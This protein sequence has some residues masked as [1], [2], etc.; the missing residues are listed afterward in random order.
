MGAGRTARLL[1]ILGAFTAGLMLC[2]GIIVFV[3]GRVSG[4]AVVQAASVGGPFNLIDQDGQP[5]SD[6]DLKG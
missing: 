5:F 4:T 6:K 3:S 2:L 1:A